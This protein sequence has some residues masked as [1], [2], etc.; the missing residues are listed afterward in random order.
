M[1]EINLLRRLLSLLV[2]V[3]FLKCSSKN[4]VANADSN[5]KKNEA[6]NNKF[7]EVNKKYKLVWADE[8]NTAGLPDSTKWGFDIGTGDWGWGNNEKEYYT[9]RNENVQVSNGILKIN[10]I[11]EDYKGSA[12]TSTRMLTKGKYAFTYGK[13]VVRAKLPTGLGTWPAI[14]MLGD[15]IKTVGWPQC[16]EIDIMEHKGSELN[17][18]YATLHYPEHFG[19]NG[20]GNTIMIKD[21]TTAFHIYTAEWSKENIKFYVDDV[22][23][24]TFLNSPTVPFNQDFHI[25]VNLA[26]GGNFAGEL[27]PSITHATMEVDY[28][29]VYQK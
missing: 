25:I 22:L 14:W 18:I 24:K 23:F 19:N 26:M 21:A 9:N 20:D 16:G 8:F 7:L 10:A 27:D 3:F 17:K 12:Y 6:E 28:V 5:A 1:N 2:S 13:V 4:F 29:R 15:N 11:K